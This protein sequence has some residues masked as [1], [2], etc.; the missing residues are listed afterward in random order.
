MLFSPLILFSILAGFSLLRRSADLL[1]KLAKES[2][3]E[4]EERFRIFFEQA[5]VGVAQIETS[6]GQPLEL[7]RGIVTSL[8]KRLI[9]EVCYG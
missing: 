8:G 6:S 9:Q 2:L 3:R 1:A 5:V 7:I 4:S